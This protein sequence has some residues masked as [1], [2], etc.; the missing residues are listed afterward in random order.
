VLPGIHP[1]RRQLLPWDGLANSFIFI[2]TSNYK[3]LPKQQKKV[4]IA[5]VS[6]S[7][8]YTNG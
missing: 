6:D 5:V 1:Q 8:N 7:G 4:F 3:V 2:K